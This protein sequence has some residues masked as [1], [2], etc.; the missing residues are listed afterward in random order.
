MSESHELLAADSEAHDYARTKAVADRMVRKASTKDFKTVCL[1]VTHLY[2]EADPHTFPA[3]L[4]VCEGNRQLYQVGN[5]GNLME[6]VSLQNTISAH[7][8]AAKAL[9]D[10]TRADGMVNGEAFHVSDGQ[11]VEFWH[12]MRLIWSTARGRDVSKEVIV[13]PT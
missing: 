5:G 10:P 12:H 1:R 7:L 9:V 3:V 4:K 2:G 11:P 13:I 6:V 8:I